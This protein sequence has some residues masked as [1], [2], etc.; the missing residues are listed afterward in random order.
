MRPLMLIL[1]VVILAGCST[2]PVSFT[3]ERPLSP[4]EI[5]HALWQD[6]VGT[7]V[8]E[9]RVDY[10]AIQ[11][12]GVLTQYL[13]LLDRA[14]PNQ[15]STN[16]RLAF[17]I[18]A[19]NAFAVQGILDQY[20]PGTLFGRY[21]FFISREYRVGGQTV[22]LYDLEREI[23]ISQFHEPRMH[24]A[25]VCAS[26][27]CP[28]LQPWAYE[29]QRLDRQLHRVTSEFVNDPSRNRFDRSKKIAFLSMIFKWFAKDFEARS[30]SVLN[31]VR[32]YVQDTSLKEDLLEA[33]YTVEFLAY[34]WRL[35]GSPP[36]P[37]GG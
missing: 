37:E 12:E 31:F 33:D 16:E 18:N 26:A 28:K 1:T 35:N 9:G 15:L 3:P 2:V 13:A 8:Q 14:D 27:S 7:H 11:K 24:F 29:G 20:S 32:E 23:L 22:N 36:I 17:W 6:A 25:I 19:Y 4:A 5:S 21:Q 34:D 10:P 30:G